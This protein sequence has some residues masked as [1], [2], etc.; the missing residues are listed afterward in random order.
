MRDQIHIA[1]LPT[2]E[3]EFA[4]QFDVKL[5]GDPQ[6]RDTTIAYFIG[7]SSHVRFSISSGEK[8][9]QISCFVNG[10]EHNFE[11]LSSAHS[12]DTIRVQQR[13]IG[14]KFEMSVFE[15][16]LV[17]HK[18]VNSKPIQ[19]QNVEVFTGPSNPGASSKVLLRRLK[20]FDVVFEPVLHRIPSFNGDSC[21]SA[22]NFGDDNFRIVGART[23]AK[24]FS[25]PWLAMLQ[26]AITVDDYSTGHS[27]MTS[28]NDICGATVIGNHYLLTGNVDQILHLLLILYSAAHC[29][30]NALC[31]Q[32]QNGRKR[33][34]SGCR[35][36]AYKGDEVAIV[37]MFSH[38]NRQSKNIGNFSIDITADNIH[39][40]EDYYDTSDGSGIV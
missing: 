23:R 15:N 31:R 16:N 35:T 6:L 19:M 36:K 10:K 28:Y 29:C 8:K 25:W 33:S 21:S 30:D 34:S 17:K 14:N 2:I 26:F 12:W 4:I 22:T 18:I 9:V 38:L 13:R 20:Y 1:T 39:I 7:L 24:S 3:K 32:Q 27:T 11:V 5:V 37:A 40:H